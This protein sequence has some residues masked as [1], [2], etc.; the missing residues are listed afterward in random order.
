MDD[1][2]PYAPPESE[3]ETIPASGGIWR[4]E[5]LLVM[6]KNAELPGRCIYCNEKA[7]LSKK[8]RINYLNIWLKIVLI[9]FF[10]IFNFLALIPILIIVQIFRKSGK[11]RIPLCQKHRKR[12]ILLTL[13][14]LAML[15]ISVGLSFTAAKAYGYHEPYF[16]VSLGFFLVAFVLALIRGQLLRATKIDAER[17]ILKGAKSPFLDSLPEYAEQ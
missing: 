9:I 11:I 14:T 3:V 6:R 7:E 1:S 8:K 17:M 16:V 4:K 10:L 5:K 12:R 15:F 2:N 13:I